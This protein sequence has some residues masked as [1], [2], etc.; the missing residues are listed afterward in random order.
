MLTKK[1]LKELR[2]LQGEI[3][4]RSAL[5]QRDVAV[6][7]ARGESKVNKLLIRGCVAWS[8]LGY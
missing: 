5:S 4:S 7:P 6:I 8:E 2:R 3:Q 1:S